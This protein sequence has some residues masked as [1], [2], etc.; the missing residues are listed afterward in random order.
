METSPEIEITIDYE[1]NNGETGHLALLARDYFEEEALEES[2][3]ATLDVDAEPLH[4]ETAAYLDADPSD[5]KWAK[6][7]IRNKPLALF[8]LAR[9]IRVVGANRWRAQ[10]ERR[11]DP[12]AG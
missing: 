9:N 5:L 11:R 1:L 8:H 2:K 10:R 3:A 6:L 12:A 4:Y 7:N